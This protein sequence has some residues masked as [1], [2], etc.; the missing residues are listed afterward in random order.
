MQ[1]S[2]TNV[3]D[4][5]VDIVRQDAAIGDPGA[6]REDSDALTTSDGAV[7]Q[8]E[9]ADLVNRRPEGAVGERH[10]PN[11]AMDPDWGTVRSL[12]KAGEGAPEEDAANATGPGAVERSH[13]VPG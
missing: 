4:D 3:T 7:R 6:A 9:K 8:L 12:G 11:P 1:G 2:D 13:H 5:A 10:A